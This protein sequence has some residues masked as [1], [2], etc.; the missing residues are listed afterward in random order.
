MDKETWLKENLQV[1]SDM[2]EYRRAQ[3][4]PIYHKEILDSWRKYLSLQCCK[5][6]G[7]P[8]SGQL[9]WTGEEISAYLD[10]QDTLEDQLIKQ[11]E[12]IND[13]SCKL[14]SWK[15]FE[16]ATKYR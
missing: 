5:P 4:L 3:N 15:D 16:E 12:E 7:K 11:F 6:S 10:F 9:N 14:L 1:S 8:I 13:A 2:D